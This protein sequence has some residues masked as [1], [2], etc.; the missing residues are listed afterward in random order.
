MDREIYETDEEQRTCLDG[1]PCGESEVVDDLR[2]FVNSQTTGRRVL[3]DG[4]IMLGH[5][6]DALVRAGDRSL[7]VGLETCVQ[8]LELITRIIV[9]E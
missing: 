4:V 7:P 5:G 1:V 3:R 9:N 2:K 8:T 6:S